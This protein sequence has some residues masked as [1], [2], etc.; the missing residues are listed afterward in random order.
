MVGTTESLGERIRRLRLDLGLSQEQLGEGAVSMSYVSLIESGARVPSTRALAALAAR[1]EVTPEFLLTGTTPDS[2]AH[3]RL[4][5]RHAQIAVR[6]GLASDA[7]IT[8]NELLALDLPVGLRVGSMACLGEALEA[9]GRLAE[10]IAAFT[11][12]LAAS[13][14]P[15]SPVSWLRVAV[16][17]SR[18]HRES[19]DLD[20]AIE[21]AESASARAAELGVA[22]SDADIELRSTLAFGYIERGDLGRAQGLLESALASAEASGSRRARGAALWN[23]SHVAD[24]R[25]ETALAYEMASSALLLFVEEDDERNLARL[26]NHLAGILLKTDPPEV[27][28]AAAL[29]LDARSHLSTVGSVVDVAYCDTELARAELLLSNPQRAIE[30]ARSALVALNEDFLETARALLVSAEAWHQ[31]GD[32]DASRQ[33]RD[34]ATAA[35][36]RCGASRQ[37]AEAWTALAQQQETTG[38]LQGALT[39][40]HRA[41]E[42]MGLSGRRSRAAVS[43]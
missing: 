24:Q 33:A 40:F 7:E 10:A 11:T 32:A 35:L 9:Q 18:C 3:L 25:G 27:E 36:E 15:L 2:H 8:V 31:L 14:G 6:S 41:T 19:G 38:D 28:R 37:A 20:R 34:M 5:L 39:S 23:L 21:I 30:Y 26:R 22:G 16:S 12:V 43:A 17:L 42:V 1:L 13:E 29:L 4:R